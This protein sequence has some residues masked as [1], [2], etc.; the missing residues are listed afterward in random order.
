MVSQVRLMKEIRTHHMGNNFVVADTPIILK[1]TP[2]TRRVFMASF[3][4]DETG[5]RHIRGN[6]YH[7]KKTGISAWEAAEGLHLKD[8]KSGELVSFE[9]SREEMEKFLVGVEWFREMNNIASP[10]KRTEKFCIAKSDEVIRTNDKDIKSYIESLIR[11]GHGKK[12]WSQLAELNPDEAKKFA[13]EQIL[14]RRRDSVREFEIAMSN[15]TWNEPKWGEFFDKNR[16]IFGLG[17][18]YQFLYQLQAQAHYGG[19]DFTGKGAQKGDFLHYT[20]GDKAKFTVLIEIKRPDS[21][22]FQIV[23]NKKKY[24]NGVPGFDVELADALSQ[25]Q[26]NSYTWDIGDSKKGVNRD[27]LDNNGIFT[28]QPRSLL[29]YGNTN[30]LDS[31]EKLNCFEIFRGQLKNTEI[32]TYDELLNRAKFIVGEMSG[33]D[34]SEK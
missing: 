7:Q 27:Q 19:T 13:D 18:R 29:I 8:V 2:R 12:F 20:L 17:L 26:V 24:R 10:E 23:D 1:E 11:G 22:I 4:E 21:Q 14:G 32:V 34:G 5:I 9:L 28:V 33:S 30:Q 31:S 25:V 16:W 6:F 3:S 15:G